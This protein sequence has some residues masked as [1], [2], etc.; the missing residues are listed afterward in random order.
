MT[1]IGYKQ[2]FND[3]GWEYAQSEG[4]Y[5]PT[6]PWMNQVTLLNKTETHGMAWKNPYKGQPDS[7]N[8]VPDAPDAK[9]AKLVTSN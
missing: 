3:G 7:G 6:H 9:P 1:F 5:R 2:K 8:P 4:P